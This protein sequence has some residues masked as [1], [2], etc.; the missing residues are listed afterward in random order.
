[1]ERIKGVLDFLKAGLIDILGRCAYAITPEALWM[2]RLVILLFAARLALR[3]L[4]GLLG[5]FWP[6]GEML[7]YNI[8]VSLA[9]LGS[10]HWSAEKIRKWTSAETE[11][12]DRLKHMGLTYRKQRINGLCGAIAALLFVLTV[13]GCLILFVS[14]PVEELA[15]QLYAQDMVQ[16]QTFL[17]NHHWLPPEELLEVEQ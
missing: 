13:I 12:L 17:D 2:I 8:R 15:R 6:L 3:I 11:R 5:W 14:E 7:M 16:I 10:M 4:K 1:M 9:S